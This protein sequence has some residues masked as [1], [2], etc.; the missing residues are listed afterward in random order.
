MHNMGLGAL[1]YQTN[2]IPTYSREKFISVGNNEH[3]QIANSKIEL[4]NDVIVLGEW[5]NGR[6]IR[7][8]LCM[9]VAE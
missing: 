2:I 6:N 8:M 4:F 1:L 9:E 5:A 7:C 3:L